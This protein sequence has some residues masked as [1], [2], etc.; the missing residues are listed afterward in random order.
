MRNLF[1]TNDNSVAELGSERLWWWRGA[2][3]AGRWR[4]C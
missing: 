4:G 2:F 3:L 1:A